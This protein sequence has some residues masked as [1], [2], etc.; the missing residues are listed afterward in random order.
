MAYN[1]N[2]QDTTSGTTTPQGTAGPAVTTPT[3]TTAP[4]AVQSAGDDVVETPV[5][6]GY[7]PGAGQPS[8][9]VG[10]HDMSRYWE[11]QG[12]PLPAQDANGVLRDANGNP[13]A[14][15]YRG[16]QSGITYSGRSRTPAITAQNQYRSDFFDAQGLYVQQG[17]RA[18][19]MR[20]LVN[21]FYGMDENRMARLQADLLD[22]GLYANGYYDEDDPVPVMTGYADSDTAS[23]YQ[24]LLHE[25]AILGKT[26]A[27]VL[28]RRKEHQTTRDTRARR[29]RGSSR[30]GGG[31]GGGNVVALQVAD[32]AAL[33]QLL[34]ETAKEELGSKVSDEELN[35]FIEA[36]QQKQAQAQMASATGQT[37]TT[38]N[39]E[40]QAE[41]FLQERHTTE[42]NGQAQVETF[43][44]FLGLLSGMGRS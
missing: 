21:Q 7:V 31:G 19:P 2:R 4:F 37:S 36:F 35:A 22:A 17:R 3:P 6:G 41:Q 8:T 14:G 38:P 18:V 20:N 43:N 42:F 33:G 16:Q 11:R 44:M 27:E 12:T 40:A 32:P 9:T 13:L 29:G 15:G 34:Q 1:R 26:P 28:R 39:A 30:G 24:S 23:A 10:R 25:A 5:V